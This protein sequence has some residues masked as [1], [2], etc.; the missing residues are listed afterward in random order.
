[1]AHP[2]RGDLQR[3]ARRSPGGQA[4]VEL[5]LAGRQPVPGRGLER[6]Q[7]AVVMRR[8]EMLDAPR[9]APGGVHDLDPVAPEAVFTVRT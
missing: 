1:M 7:L 3:A 2:R 8:A 5:A 6:F 9:A 4:Q